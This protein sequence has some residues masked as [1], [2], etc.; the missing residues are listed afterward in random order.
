MNL[1]YCISYSL[2]RFRFRFRS[3]PSSSVSRVSFVVRRFLFRLRY[4]SRSRFHSCFSF[5]FSFPALRSPFSLLVPHSRFRIRF[6][7]VSVVI[8]VF[9]SVIVFV[10]AF[11]SV[12]VFVSVLV[13]VSAY[14]SRFPLIVFVVLFRFL[15][16]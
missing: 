1:F 5:R 8:P 7:F 9:V 6:R 10:S 11:V 4:C 12:S 3:R 15:V 13:S 14:R 2:L 16:L